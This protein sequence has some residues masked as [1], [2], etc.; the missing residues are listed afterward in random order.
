MCDVTDDFRNLMD[1]VGAG[2]DMSAVDRLQAQLLRATA[3]SAPYARAARA[4]MVAMG[5]A[6]FCAQLE[7]AAAQGPSTS[8]E[9][10]FGAEEQNRKAPL[11]RLLPYL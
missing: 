8:R 4:K 10:S 7:D 1:I 11:F 9:Q 5:A 6:A 2:N 3:S